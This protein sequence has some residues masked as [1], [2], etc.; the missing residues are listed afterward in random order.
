MSPEIAARPETLEGSSTR[1]SRRVSGASVPSWELPKAGVPSLAEPP[2]SDGMDGGGSSNV[3]E[4]YVDAG[5]WGKNAWPRY[6]LGVVFVVFMWFVVGGWASVAVGSL[7]GVSAGQVAT[8]SSSAGPIAGYLVVSAPFVPLLLATLLVAALLHRR[9]PL[10]LV[11]GRR[12]IDWG[13]V[14]TGLGVWFA[15]AALGGLVGFLVYPSAFSLGPSLAAF[16]PFALLALVLT[17][18]QAIAEEVF[19][20]GYLVQGASLVSS[21]FL[22][23]AVAS[24]ALFMLPHLANP[25]LVLPV[26]LYHFVFGAF[27][28]W[29]SLRDGTLEL[30][31]GA[32]AANNLFGAV[33]LGFEGSA[34]K[35]PSLFYTD[36]FVP[37]YSLVQFLVAAAIFYVAAFVLVKR[38]PKKGR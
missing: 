33:V 8:G 15:L 22:F 1:T 13:R 36:R 7:L 37:A 6:L 28:A 14:G 35:T 27:F 19:F 3:N 26:A 9:N 4:A 21:N 2:A 18:V 10:T 30:A 5:R 24:G 23:L 12:S 31:I 25:G 34:L 16:V 11:T 32:H 17:P 20:R 29:V 38:R